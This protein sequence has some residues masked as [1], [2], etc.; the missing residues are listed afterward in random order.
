MKK[1]KAI[2]IGTSAGGMK[3]LTFILSNLPEDYPMTVFIAQHL[4][5]VQ[6]GYFVQYY[7]E[8]C[9]LR[10]KEPQSGE[11]IQSGFVY[12]APPNYHLL[13]EN[14]M[15]MSLS[16]SEKVNYA[17][18][19]IDVLFDSA[20]DAYLSEL[21]GIILT[22]ANDDGAKGML[23]IKKNG[24]LTIVQD[25]ANSEYPVMPGAAIKLVEIDYIKPLDEIPN[26]LKEIANDMNLKKQILQ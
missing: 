17:R 7:S 3:A 23:T 1:Y 2:V 4:H 10:V 16:T 11:K 9:K 18:P 24:G 13:I 21:I 20:S 15:S 8:L 14:D 6:D 19:S 22:G 26:L 5:P 25:P 12:F